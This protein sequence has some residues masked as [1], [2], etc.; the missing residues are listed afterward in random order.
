MKK[1]LLAIAINLSIISLCYSQNSDQK[2][3]AEFPGGNEAFGD[4]IVHQL[5]CSD[6]A[7]YDCENARVYVRFAIDT[8]GQII[9][10]ET[11]IVNGKDR[12]SDKTQKKII[13][14]F[15]ASPQWDIFGEMPSD[16]NIMFPRVM[17]LSLTP[18]GL[19]SM[20]KDYKKE[21]K[22]QKKEAKRKAKNK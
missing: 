1:N 10:S 19:S 7:L 4:F 18:N 20:R 8:T 14:A 2:P 16:Q 13:A 9:T 12:V 21:L 22:R 15:N 3:K 11:Q 6:N 5:C 17:P